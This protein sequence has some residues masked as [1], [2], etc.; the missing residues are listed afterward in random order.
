MQDTKFYR[1]GKL[2]YRLRWAI[3]GLW[4][5]TILSCIPFVPHL[6]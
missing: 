5:I 4:G 2:I 1:W 3:I 6:I